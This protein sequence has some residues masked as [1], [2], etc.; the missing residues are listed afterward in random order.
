LNILH[1]TTFLQGG[2]GKVVIDLTQS[3]IEK[4]HKVSVA[5]TKDSVQGYCNYPEHLKSLEQMDIPVI[6][7]DSTF[8]REHEKNRQA[9]RT[10]HSSMI[11]QCPDVIHSHASIPSLVSMIA[12]SRLN[13]KIPIIQTM[14]GWGIFKTDE[15]ECQDIEI[16]NR[17]DHVVSISK[18]SEDLLLGKGLSNPSKSCIY[19]GLEGTPPVDEQSDDPHLVK[20]KSLRKDGHKIIGVIGTVDARKNQSLV[21]EALSLLPESLLFQ[22]VFVGEGD[23][24]A[25]YREKAKS[26]SLDKKVTF[27]GYKPSARSFVSEFDLLVSAS[28]SEG[29]APL[30]VLEAFADKTLVLAADTLENKEVIE[31]SKNGFLFHSDDARNLSHKL[32]ICLDL[33]D[34]DRVTDSAHDLFRNRYMLEKTC[35]NYLEIYERCMAKNH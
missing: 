8:S 3:A 27:T 25:A 23:D 15:Q 33:E 2:A 9:S 12:S 29:A 32:Q 34:G 21:L 1:I 20:I 19:N 4:G 6:F 14:H 16:L 18:A 35:R 5:C 13:D 26:L 22:A 31:D 11:K 24:L 30:A 28:L 10:L 7:L 17:V